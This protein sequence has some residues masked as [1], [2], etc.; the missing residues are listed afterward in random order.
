M[1]SLLAIGVPARANVKGVAVVVGRAVGVFVLVGGRV[2]DG[3]GLGIP[4]KLST[5]QAD[6]VVNTIKAG[7]TREKSLI[8]KIR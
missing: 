5:W 6:M 8:I 7:R 1:A 3:V 4:G 2:M